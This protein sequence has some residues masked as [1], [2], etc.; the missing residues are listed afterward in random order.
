MIDNCQGRHY[1]GYGSRRENPLANL[2]LCLP[3]EWANRKLCRQ[4]AGV[5]DTTCFRTRHELF[6][7]RLEDRGRSLPAIDELLQRH[8]L[9]VSSRIVDAHGRVWPLSVLVTI[10]F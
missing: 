8:V 2:R 3:E 5:P 4:R 10:L 9:W 6:L 7:E 1:L